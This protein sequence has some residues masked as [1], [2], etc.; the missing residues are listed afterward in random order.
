[1][2]FFGQNNRDSAI[3]RVPGLR[4]AG[5][6]L[7][8]L[9]LTLSATAQANAEKR[10]LKLYF[11]H[12][13]ERA[14]ITY[15]INGRYSQAGLTKL[16]RF[17]RDWRRNEPTK[18]DPLLFDVVW[19]AYQQTGS[20][21]YIHVVSG[22]RSPASNEMLRRTRGGQAKK[23][24]HMLGKALDFYI[25]G[26]PLS[27][28]RAIGFKIQGGGVGY[29]PRSGSPFVHL[30]VGNVRAWPRMSREELARLF[31]DGKTLHLPADGKPLPGYKQALAEYQRRRGQPVSIDRSTEVQV[32]S[33]AAPVRTRGDANATDGN[34]SPARGLL[35]ALFG[36]GA[37]E[38]EDN[39]IEVPATPKAAPRD[40]APAPRPVA[41]LPGVAVAQAET[42]PEPAT[43]AAP[44][45]DDPAAI[46]AKLSASAVPL[47][48]ANPRVL[49]E[50]ETA[51]PEQRVDVA[52]NVPLPAS[53]PQLETVAPPI[54][55][56]A[57]T[58][59]TTTA[60]TR[61][62]SPLAAVVPLPRPASES[63][64]VLAAFADDPRQTAGGLRP[65]HDKGNRLIAA[66]PR[67]RP[68][69]TTDSRNGRLTVAAPSAIATPRMAM[70]N[71]PQ[72]ERA[73]AI[74]GN[75]KTTPKAARPVASQARPEPHSK[76][77]P[78]GPES[79]RWAL[80]VAR[81]PLPAQP[82]LASAT[83]R[84]APAAVYTA[85][86]NSRD[87]RQDEPH[88]FTGKAVTFLTV[89]KFNPTN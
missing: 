82:P 10:T 24:Q 42:R 67:G 21:D 69:I 13:G 36:G 55:I 38:E 5:Y 71:T 46:I 59:A 8:A 74:A 30:D 22:Y 3:A 89:A 34:K 87:I 17:L 29:Y 77:V 75:V 18:M 37:D 79:A 39:S 2:V 51:V 40:A 60:V 7:A 4:W 88:R 47:P 48:V 33:N 1:M 31:P 11:M 41:G 9:M 76:I 66:V 56:P 19:E 50:T 32:A 78:I 28:L 52:M 81:V 45:A 25:P 54:G 73:A 85:G 86:F 6:L 70:L 72:G 65:G 23:S 53:R 20:R 68:E 84:K 83:I 57:G 58:D 35:A 26:V 62:G 14:E 63:I 15:K 12:T 43:E 27:K 61:R 16:N 49:A 64:A 80:A 44:A